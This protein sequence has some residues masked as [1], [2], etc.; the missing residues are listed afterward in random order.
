[1]FDHSEVSK[2][3]EEQNAQF[4]APKKPYQTLMQSISNVFHPLLVL[5]V[6]AIVI[7]IFTPMSI[8]PLQVK[9]FFVG[10]VFFYSLFMPA[11]SITLMHVFHLVGHWALRDRRDRALPFLV[12]F[13]CY[14]MNLYALHHTGFIP[15]WVLSIYW[16][17]VILTFIA[18]IVS[19]WWKISAHASADAAG[20]TAFLILHYW[21]P[22]TMPLWLG[23]A[24]V[25]IVGF[26]CTT[27]LYLG[28][29]TLAQVAAGSLLGICTM[30][31]ATTVFS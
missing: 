21:F 19:F 30:L 10:E 6:T 11:L 9:L 7:C 28:R 23:L 29:H 3:R 22:L 25:I 18:W 12:N 14:S 2:I 26:V 5:T 24:A 1:M 8:Y 13:I 27:R 31:F 4:T 16:A 20:A 15:Q 17:S